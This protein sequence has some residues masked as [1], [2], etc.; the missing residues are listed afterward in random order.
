MSLGRLFVP[1]L[2]LSLLASPIQAQTGEIKSYLPFNGPKED[3]QI[4]F[5]TLQ[6]PGRYFIGGRGYLRIEARNLEDKPHSLRF[7]LER[8][9]GGQSGYRVHKT[10]QLASQE[11]ATCYLPLPGTSMSLRLN[12][13]LDGGRNHGMSLRNSNNSGLACLSLS[14]DAESGKWIKDDLRRLFPAHVI[15]TGLQRFA[16]VLVRRANEIPGTWQLLSGFDLIAVDLAGGELNAETQTVLSDYLRMGGR[17]ML[18]GDP[19]SP[20]SPMGRLLASGSDGFTKGRSG[21]GHWAWAQDRDQLKGNSKALQ[22]WL[23][24]SGFFLARSKKHSGSAPDEFYRKLDIPGLGQVPVR[25]FFFLILVFAVVVGP[26]NLFYWRRKKKPQMLL[27]SVPIAGIA[28]TAMILVYGFLSEGFDIKGSIRSMTI[29]DQRDHSAANITQRSLFAGSGP[30]KLDLEPGTHLETHNR[31][32]GWRDPLT[33]IFDMDMDQ[34]NRLAGTVLPSRTETNLVT[35]TLSR[36]RERLAFKRDE[37]GNYRV[38]ETG[39]LSRDKQ[40]AQI[41]FRDLDGRYWASSDAGAELTQDDSLAKRT[42]GRLLARPNHVEYSQTRT[43]RNRYWYR[44]RNQEVN[45]Y[46]STMKAQREI[47]TQLKLFIADSF[48]T[49]MPPGSYLIRAQDDPAVDDLGLNVLYGARIQLV[50]GLLAKEDI[51]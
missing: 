20:D 1:A 5:S 39:G 35:W 24:S 19:G 32:R 8:R 51:Q 30:D 6:T 25:L 29:L 33:H 12:V 27:I 40:H 26:I 10:I 44:N 9:I 3:A 23:A 34:G 11:R 18:L 38:L 4:L 31:V 48:A 36:T 28:F 13:S 17:L 41:V 50:M 42:L 47:G 49:S 21:F 15:A 14:S 22:S 46:S 43:R 37:N 16:P 2:L 7:D 45:Q